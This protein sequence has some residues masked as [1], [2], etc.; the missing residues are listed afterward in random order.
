MKAGLLQQAIDL[1]PGTPEELQA[2]MRTE[3]E[4][5]AKVVKEAGAKIE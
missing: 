3:T 2:Y 4:K 1:Q 5:W